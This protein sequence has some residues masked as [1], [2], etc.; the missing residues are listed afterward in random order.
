MTTTKKCNLTSND[1]YDAIL[2]DCK[3]ELEKRKAPEEWIQSYMNRV[4]TILDAYVE[5]LGDG[6]EAKYSVF[7]RFKKVHLRIEIPGDMYNPTDSGIVDMDG[8][9]GNELQPLLRQKNETVFYGYH[10][11]NNTIYISTPRIR[12]GTMLRSPMLWG[13]ILGLVSGA[14]CTLLPE[15]VCEIIVNDVVSSVNTVA[16]NLIFCVMGP[17]ILVSMITAVSALKSVN[18][19]TSMGFRLIGRFAKCI[20]SVMFV[21]IAVSLLFFSV[22]GDGDVDIKAK[23][24]VNLILNIFPKDPI[25]PIKDSNTP[26][27]VIMGL[28]LG[29]ALIIPGDEVKGLKKIVS[30]VG[31]W[32]MTVMDLVQF[33]LPIVPFCS[34]FIAVAQ[35]T[36][37]SLLDGWQFIVAMILACLICGLIKF[38][39][40]ARKYRIKPSVLWGKLKP[41]VVLAFV[42]GNITSIMKQEYE[43]CENELGISHNFTSFW[44][45]LSQAMLS[46]R[47]T[48]NF[49]IPPFLILK[50]TDKPISMAFLVVL[51]IVVLELSIADPGTAAGWTILFA[52]LGLPSE[53]VGLFLTFELFTTSVNAAYGALQMGLEAIESAYSFDAINLERVKGHV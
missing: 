34:V 4:S 45:P 42:S 41:L 50:F 25:S 32:V 47:A 21:G 10:A 43:F 6:I 36:T 15:D 7:A 53:F 20:L 49:V 16:L 39:H 31:V 28:V 11:G 14:V 33:V 23:D 29:A 5:H 1:R 46:P 9:E 30:Q 17:V 26:Q 8:I 52:S 40:V 12:Q 3:A 48:L 24:L 35:K 19:L 2:S 18:D 51:V 44:I 13:A 38:V 27:L 37:T 22:F